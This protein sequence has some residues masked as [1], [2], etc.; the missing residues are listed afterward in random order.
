MPRTAM[1]PDPPDH[2]PLGL[3]G[4]LFNTIL[5]S[6]V[7]ACQR[8]TS[9]EQSRRLRSESERFFLWGDG[10]SV[11]DGQLDKA[12]ATSSELYQTTLSALYELGSIINDDLVRAAAPTGPV[13]HLAGSRELRLLLREASAILDTS[14]ATGDSEGLSDDENGP[15]SL[16]DVLDDMVT[17]IDCLMDLSLALESTL[18]YSES[19][20]IEPAVVELGEMVSTHTYST[21][22]N[23]IIS[24]YRSLGI[25]TLSSSTMPDDGNAIYLGIDDGGLPGSQATIALFGGTSR[26]RVVHLGPWE[27]QESNPRR[28]IWQ[29]TYQNDVLEHYF[30][31]NEPS[32]VYPHTLHARHHPYH[33]SKPVDLERYVIFLEPHRIRYINNEGVC[34]HDES[35]NVKYEFTSVESSIQFQGDLR[36]KD[37]V[38]FYDMDVV[39]TNINRRTDSFG[40]IKGVATTQRLKLWR[41]RWT[42]LYSLSIHQNKVDRQYRDY[43]LGDFQREIRHRDDRAKQIRLEA[44]RKDSDSGR[45]LTTT[46]QLQLRRRSSETSESRL[47]IR[48]T[49]SIRY[50]AIQFSERA[51]YRRFIETW[52][53]CQSPDGLS[54]QLQLPIRGVIPTYLTQEQPQRGTVNLGP[55]PS[56]LTEATE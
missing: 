6:C 51:A 37:L 48:S 23:S 28:V 24:S 41:D 39:W 45:R 47:P 8:L 40:N 14:N 56:N 20:S 22:P 44:L 38:D 46:N 19:G 43:I 26:E 12:L 18:A 7:N 54:N 15:H 11:T 55:G 30:P 25:R 27:V 13:N 21:P 31:S 32:D 3:I 9:T 50:L 5:E 4:N 1:E 49:D 2:P 33:H 53:S 35:V 52:G 10:V 17:Y 29:G 16:E 36:R 34:M 42:C